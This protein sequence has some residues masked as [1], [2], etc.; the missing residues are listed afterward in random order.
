MIIPNE[1]AKYP[2]EDQNNIGNQIHVGISWIPKAKQN[3]GKKMRK[4]SFKKIAP[5]ERPRWFIISGCIASRKGSFFSKVQTSNLNS[6]LNNHF[7]F[8]LING[9]LV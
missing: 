5:Y 6:S 7:C 2:V 1:E 3:R 8:S 9:V 4:T